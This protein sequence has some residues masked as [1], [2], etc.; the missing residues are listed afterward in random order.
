M[1]KFCKFADSP[2][3]LKSWKQGRRGRLHEHLCHEVIC[4]QRFLLKA[5]ESEG[6]VRSARHERKH[7]IS[8]RVNVIRSGFACTDL[9]E[10]MDS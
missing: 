2:E 4:S 8:S 1:Q 9:D 7:V 6:S 10:R 5:A 3:V